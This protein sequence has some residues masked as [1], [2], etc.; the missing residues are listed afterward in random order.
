MAESVGPTREWESEGVAVEG[1]G[2][3]TSVRRGRSAWNRVEPRPGSA[4]LSV[5]MDVGVLRWWYRSMT[6]IWCNNGR[7]YISYDYPQLNHPCVVDP[8]HLGPRYLK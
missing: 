5:A 6:N 4:A 8:P 3:E 2:G 1:G 7:S